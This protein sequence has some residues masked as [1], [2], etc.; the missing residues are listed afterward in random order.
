M[1]WAIPENGPPQLYRLDVDGSTTQAVTPA[2]VTVG[3]AGWSAS[4]DGSMV[5]VSTGQ[6]VELF[7]IAGGESRRVP[8]SERSSVVGWIESGL[9]ISEDPGAGGIVLSLDPATGKRT[10][11]A[12][13]QPRDPAGIMSLDLGT[14]VVTPDGR[15]Y[16]YTWHR[17]TSDLYLVEGW[18]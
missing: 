15:G 18:S 9:L 12:D 16:G 7:P 11:W 1:V 14:F 4:P 8:G 10:V 6:G 5:A 17:A 2:G 3:Y 13:I